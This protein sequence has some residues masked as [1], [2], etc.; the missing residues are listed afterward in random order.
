MSPA[1]YSEGPE[2][3]D[4]L[5]IRNQR[6]LLQKD[7]EEYLDSQLHVHKNGAFLVLDSSKNFKE[8]FPAQ[9]SISINS[10]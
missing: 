1:V 4:Y 2:D 6:G 10:W 3:P 7:M 9:K 8:V 5:Y